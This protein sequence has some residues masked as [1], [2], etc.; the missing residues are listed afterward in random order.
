MSVEHDRIPRLRFTPTPRVFVFRSS[1][2]A[3]NHLLNDVERYIVRYV[4]TNEEKCYFRGLTTREDV[5]DI[6]FIIII[7]IIIIISL[8]SSLLYHI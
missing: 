5:V 8:S 3:E 1:N 4:V 7:I 6:I 2:R